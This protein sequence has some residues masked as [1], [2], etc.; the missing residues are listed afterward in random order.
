MNEGLLQG[1]NTM[2][3]AEKRLE[4]IASNLANVDSNGFKRTGVTAREFERVLNGRVEREVS[5]KANYNFSQGPLRETGNVYDLGLSGD[6]FFVVD[7]K[8]G[9]LLTRDGRFFVD[10]KGVLQTFEGL[11]VAWDGARGALD[12]NGVEPTIDSEGYVRQGQSQVG[13]IRIV[14]YEDKAS[15]RA[16]TGGLFSADVSATPLPSTAQVR[17]GYLET[18]NVSAVDEMVAMIAVQRQFEAGAKLMSA[19]DQ[20]YR[21]LTSPR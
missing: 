21:R 13:R 16:Q 19:I 4:A 8:D 2:R 12:P 3:T 17:Q 1:V 11:P 6:G 10:D 7:G 15:L 5:L 18:S 9:E 14:D 20:T